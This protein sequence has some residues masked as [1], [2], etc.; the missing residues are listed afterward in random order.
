VI[1]FEEM[2]RVRNPET[3]YIVTANNRVVGEEYPHYIALDY[4]PG[5]RARRITDRLLALNKASTE[6]MAAIHAEKTSIPAQAFARLM[7]RINPLDE[8]STRA[9]ERLTRWDGVI[10]RDAVEPTIYNAFRDQ[11]V[12]LVLEPI[13]GPLAEEGLNGQG[14]GG[15][16]HVASLRSRFHTM[17][18][19]DDRSLLLPEA[20]WDS[21]MAK[22]L[23]G[24]VARLQQELGKD[25]DGWQWG[26]THRTQP[27]HTLSPSFP[28]LAELLDPPSVPMGGDADTPQAAGYSPAQPFSM[29][30]MSV[31]RYAFDLSDWSNSGWIVPL[32]ASGHP[33]SSHYADQ[34]PVWREVQLTPMLYDWRR[35]A[36]EAESHQELKPAY[37]GESVRQSKPL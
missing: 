35:I 17:V 19:E 16:W 28:H 9:K 34:M 6:D 13:L 3:G 15:P 2:P 14:R 31:A 26:K 23:S 18:Q 24:A 22:A 25:M 37:N 10:Q 29:T 21:L 20:D 27:Q 30:G 32:G 5:F 7:A 8:A 11:L 36:E 1:P 4:R 33:G 12:R